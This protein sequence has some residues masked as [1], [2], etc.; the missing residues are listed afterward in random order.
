LDRASV[1]RDVQTLINGQPAGE[2]LQGTKRIGIIV[3]GQVGDH[4]D[5]GK[6]ADMAVATPG[7]PVPLAQIGHTTV[8]TQDPIVWTR[9]GE[10]VV[11]VEADTQDDVQPADILAA[12]GLRVNAIVEHLPPGYRIENGGDKELSA[13]ANTAIYKLL[14]MTLAV[15]LLLLMIQLQSVGR[16]L[17]VLATA[18]LGLIGAVAALLVTGRPFGFVALLGLIALAG[19]IMRN[20]IILVDQVQGEHRDGQDLRT[21]II[22]ATVARSRPV[23]LTALAAVLAFIPLCFNI[24]WGPMAIVMIGG[25]IGAT[26]LTLLALPALYA[27]AFGP[28]PGDQMELSDA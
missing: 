21:A 9:N 24:F 3:R 28:R 25:L 11:T 17:L 8:Q 22:R 4:G 10:R 23:V 27:L 6:L 2:V 26:V 13:K 5:I 16:T 15:M 20:A 7:G 18:P 14:P 1:G 19:M 12:A